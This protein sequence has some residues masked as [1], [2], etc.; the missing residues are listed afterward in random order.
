MLGVH[1]LQYVDLLVHASL[2]LRVF[3]GIC[4]SYS[5]VYCLLGIRMWQRILSRFQI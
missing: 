4:V 5:L 3:G 1:I 2:Y